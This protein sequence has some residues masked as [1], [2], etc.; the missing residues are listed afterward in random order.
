VINNYSENTVVYRMVSYIYNPSMGV[1]YIFISNLV[2]SLITLLILLPYINIFRIKYNYKLWKKVI[3]YS[4]PLL[5][6]G[7]AGTI[8]ETFDRVLLKYL[9]PDRLRAME[10]LGIY[11]A[12]YKISIIMTIFIQTF[13]FA[14][15]PFFFLESK[16]SGHKEMYAIVL[17]YFVLFGS[18][19]F[20][21]TTL[22]IDI[23][24]FFV[25]EKYYSGLKVVPILLMAN[26]F[27]GIHYN[28]SIWYKLTSKT[29][30]GAYISVMGAVITIVLNYIFIPIYGYMASAWAT[31]VCYLTMAIVSYMYGQR[32]YKIEYDIRRIIMYILVSYIVYEIYNY[33]KDELI[34]N[35]IILSSIFF[36]SYIIFIAITEKEMIK[37]VINNGLLN[38]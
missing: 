31:F 10:Q 18:I 26:L 9:L 35:N 15:E 1:G 14:A 28:L 23:V 19:I 8:N 33:V 5:I 13:R 11:G 32:H 34:I 3:S 12:C 37:K 30:Y 7:L 4:L 25:G 29:L 38:K 22:Y 6:V 17:K 20:L 27:L 21:I 24:K 16:S 36:V 2:A